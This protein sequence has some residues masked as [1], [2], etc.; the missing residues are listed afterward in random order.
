MKQY[1]PAYYKN[2]QCI[3]QKCKDNCCIGWDIMIDE[4]SY[5]RYQKV[6]TPFKK[7][8]D[9]GI[10]HGKEPMFCMDEQGRGAFLNQNNLCDIY[11]ELGEDALCEICTQH[12]R[13]HNEYGHIRQSGLGLA[14][15]EVARLILNDSDFKVEESIVGSESE[16][17][18]WADE[19]MRIELY[20][21]EILKDQ[22]CPIEERMDKIFD[23][24]AAYQE[25]LNLTG[26]LTASLDLKTVQPKYFMRKINEKEYLSYWF[27]F[28]GNLDYMDDKFQTLLHK[29]IKEYKT[30]TSYCR[31]DQY[32]E[33]LLCYFIYRHFIKSYD[34]DNLTDKIKF[35]ILSTVM[36]EV[37]DQYC[38]EYE[39]P[40]EIQ[41]IARRY[42]KE[43]EYS[44]ENMEVIFEELLFD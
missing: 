9:Q 18:E 43:I 30:W 44:E 33:R 11:I 1:I 26:E 13:F 21:L 5:N 14:C 36:I 35:A 31:N 7:C 34:D 41:D 40:F 15:E 28:Y 10:H 39:I 2:F 24:T 19:L 6:T 8:L 38:K 20:L 27:D 37:V 42:S 25:K 22:E 23:L 3:A 16:D 12:P 4:Q 17:D 29:A 32:I